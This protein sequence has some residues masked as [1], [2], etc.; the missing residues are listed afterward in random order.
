MEASKI[1]LILQRTN[2][3]FMFPLWRFIPAS[4]KPFSYF[5]CPIMFFIY[6]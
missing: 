1:G 4:I 5:L 6:R 3:T 2:G